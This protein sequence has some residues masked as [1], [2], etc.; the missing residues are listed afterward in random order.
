MYR[1]ISPWEGE[2]SNIEPKLYPSRPSLFHSNSMGTR[3][4][5]VYT[6]TVPRS[7]FLL[8]Q[9]Q[10]LNIKQKQFLQIQFYLS[11]KQRNQNYIRRTYRCTSLQ[12]I[13]TVKAPAKL[14][15]ANLITLIPDLISVFRL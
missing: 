8:Q 7:I 2:R 1:A 5:Q 6:R 10:H 14:G 15:K 3:I 9:K 13:K 4:W 12:T 11:G